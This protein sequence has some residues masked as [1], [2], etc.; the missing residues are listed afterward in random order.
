MTNHR[1]FSDKERELIALS[2]SVAAGCRPCTERHVAGAQ[3]AGACVRGVALAVETAL[4]V[5]QSATRAMDQWA[6]Q[7]QGTRPEVDEAFRA[8]KRLMVELESV[9]AAAA[10]NSGPDLEA[11]VQAASGSGAT[12]EQLRAAIAIGGAAKRAAEHELGEA[13]GKCCEP[14]PAAA[15]TGCGCR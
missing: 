6:G 14:A 9:A 12:P 15:T 7:C 8:E 4:A 5:R 1:A 10:V 13:G 11:H 3:S 2:A